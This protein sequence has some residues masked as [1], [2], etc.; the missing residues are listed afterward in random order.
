MG[1]ST[2]QARRECM[3]KSISTMPYHHATHARVLWNRQACSA[4]VARVADT[5]IE[6]AH[7]AAIVV[8]EV[9]AIAACRTSNLQVLV[10]LTC[11]SVTR[12]STCD[13]S[14]RRAV[15]KYE[16]RVRHGNHASTQALAT[17]EHQHARE[18]VRQRLYFGR[19]PAR[20]SWG[21]LAHTVHRSQHIKAGCQGVGCAQLGASAPPPLLLL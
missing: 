17:K 20:A 14:A 1:L 21:L 18:Q 19:M 2:Q 16:D 8:V 13:E 4:P 10:T 7:T 9:G 5:Q 12:V 3:W 11:D 15:Q 6:V